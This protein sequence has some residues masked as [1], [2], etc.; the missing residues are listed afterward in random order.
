MN[1]VSGISLSLRHND[2][3]GETESRYFLNKRI[4]KKFLFIHSKHNDATAFLNK[5]ALLIINGRAEKIITPNNVS[6]Y[7]FFM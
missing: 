4:L 3:N 2:G 6:D 1:I 5:V 7:M